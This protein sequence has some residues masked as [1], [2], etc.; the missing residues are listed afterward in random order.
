MNIRKPQQELKPLLWPP[1]AAWGLLGPL[2]ACCGI[3]EPPGTSWSPPGASWG[4]MVRIRAPGEA[5]NIGIY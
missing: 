3:L 5:Q 4:L 1:G 2:G